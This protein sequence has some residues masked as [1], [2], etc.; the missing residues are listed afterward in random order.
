MA[1]PRTSTDIRTLTPI[2]TNSIAP[3][4]DSSIEALFKLWTCLEQR[5]GE[6]GDGA[7]PEDETASI[8][9]T[10]SVIIEQCALVPAATVRDV[11]CKLAIW[12][13]ETPD[14][15]PGPATPRADAIAYSAFCDLI[16]LT[17]HEDF[18]RQKD[19]Q[20]RLPASLSPTSP[21][22]G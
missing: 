22:K 7:P 1:K 15:P 2:E 6:R 3:G 4:K 5:L 19:S 14:L 8:I 16:R 12:Q 13:A 17:G 20:N 11:L 10:Q 21:P 9:H 18:L